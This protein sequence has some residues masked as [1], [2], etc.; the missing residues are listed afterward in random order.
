MQSNEDYYAI[1]FGLFVFKL[2]LF[3]LIVSYPKIS[4]DFHQFF[5]KKGI[6]ETIFIPNN[7]LFN[8]HFKF[9]KDLV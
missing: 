2:S 5:I 4:E 7:Y 9:I 1:S 3:D 6:F 8:I